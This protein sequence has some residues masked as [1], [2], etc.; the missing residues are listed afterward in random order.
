MR[1]AAATP[2]R[3]H[4]AS[5]HL[6]ACTQLG[7]GAALLQATLCQ[8]GAAHRPCTGCVLYANPTLHCQLG[9]LSFPWGKR[10]GAEREVGVL[11][12]SLSKCAARTRS[13]SQMTWQR[14]YPVGSFLLC[15]RRCQSVC[16]GRRV[17]RVVGLGAGSALLLSGRA[18]TGWILP[19]PW[20]PRAH[21]GGAVHPAFCQDYLSP[22]AIPAAPFSQRRGETRAGVAAPASP[23]AAR[24]ILLPSWCTRVRPL[25][26]ES[27]SAGRGL[28]KKRTPVQA[29]S[30]QPKAS[31]KICG[32]SSGH[33]AH[34]STVAPQQVGYGWRPPGTVGLVPRRAPPRALVLSAEAA[35]PDAT[36]QRA[37]GCAAQR[38]AAQR[39]AGPPAVPVLLL[40]AAAT[41]APWQAR[42]TE[43]TIA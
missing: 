39:A 21:R 1:A 43:P 12:R 11:S 20:A 42:P 34:H 16:A 35:C 3:R 40:V 6:A 8:F 32:S 36:V 27:L 9:T 13:S 18:P 37:S 28:T 14:F 7:P 29:R 31:R 26:A 24:K 41:L 15:S 22:L 30:D 25:M 19:C 10:E 17:V 23:Q 4:S 5:R 38:S 2:P 33:S